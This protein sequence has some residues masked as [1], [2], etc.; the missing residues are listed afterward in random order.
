MKIRKVFLLICLLLTFPGGA[1]LQTV[2]TRKTSQ[3]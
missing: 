3:R 2:Y 1:Q